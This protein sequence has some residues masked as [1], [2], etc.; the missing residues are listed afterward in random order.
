MSSRTRD[1][2]IV[3]GSFA[4]LALALAL[5]RG[6]GTGIDVTLVEQGDLAPSES[7]SDPRAF[8]LGE[9]SRAL[10]EA[11]GVWPALAAEAEPVGR[12][13]ITDGGL[14]DVTRPVR[15]AYDTLAGGQAQM[16][17]VP[18]ARL[19]QALVE[20]VGGEPGIEVLERRAFRSLER[21]PGRIDIT[22][23]GGEPVAARLLVA[24]DGARSAIRQAAGIGTVGGPY[25]QWGIALTIRHERPHDGVA[26]QHFL[27]AGPFALLPL[28]GQRS[29]VTWTEGE[30]EARR[31]L[32][33]DVGA[34][35]DEVQRRTG[36]HLGEITLESRPAGWPLSSHLARALTAPRLALVGDAARNVHPIAGQGVNL[37][38]RDV[39]ALAEVLADGLRVGL[40]AGDATILRSYERWRRADGVQSAAAFSA[41]NALFSN[42]IAP[43]RAMRDI[44]LEVVHRLPAI[45][46][47]LVAEAAGLAGEVP[48]LMRGEAL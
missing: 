18:A 27:P 6:L 14:D 38:F 29:C 47:M 42:D 20:A 37:G 28:T 16:L 46:S 4:G 26:T 41:L 32:G 21:R 19:R 33:L 23:D 44:G 10:L 24:A 31:M 13:D 45:K 34:L 12:V 25:G 8:A 5:V 22:S 2:A 3:G 7:G 30:G 48:R 39:A 36:W 11:I 9:G 1:V 40:D 35:R 17:I 15:L 43:I